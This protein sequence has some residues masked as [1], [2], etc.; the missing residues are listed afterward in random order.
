MWVGKTRTRRGLSVLRF[1]LRPKIDAFGSE[2]LAAEFPY[3]HFARIQAE[4][5]P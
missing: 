5:S 2:A 4:P 1:H 3:F